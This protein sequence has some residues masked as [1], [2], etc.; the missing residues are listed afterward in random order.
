MDYEPDDLEYLSYCVACGNIIDYC[1]GHGEIGDPDGYRI[2]EQHDNDNHDDCH[3][4][5][6][7]ELA[8]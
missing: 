2:L 1:Q 6:C 3:P 4:V 7:E 5:G 8:Q